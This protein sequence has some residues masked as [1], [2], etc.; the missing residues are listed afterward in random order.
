VLVAWTLR[1]GSSPPAEAP[2]LAAVRR[3]FRNRQLAGGLVLMSA[4]S[5]LFGVLAVLGPLHLSRAGW[6]A[7]AIG[8]VW[9]VGAGLEAV[10]AP[11]AGRI[12]DRRG[13][14]VP[15]RAAL[16]VG[17]LASLGL[18]TGARPLFY[19]P[20]IV[21]AAVAYGTLF[22]P[23]FTM[24]ANGAEH[25]GLAQ[26]MAFGLMSAAWATGAVVGPAA[27]GAIAS[28]TGDWIPFLLG[29]VLCGSILFVVR[30][31]RAGERAA[32]FEQ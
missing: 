8:G 15:V 12:I 7:A 11:I 16:A 3:A 21:V 25:T 1:L 32:A 9:L 19:A 20:L 13:P 29:S 14:L 26:G 24:I 23:A 28:A 5:L 4:P 2:S 22:T 31:R 17:S 30:P 6:G 18:A 27:G 10:Q